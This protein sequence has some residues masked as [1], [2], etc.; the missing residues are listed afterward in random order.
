MLK[1]VWDTTDFISQLPPQTLENT[2]LVS[3]DVVNL[4]FN[5]PYDLRIKAIDYW[6]KKYPQTLETAINLELVIEGLKFILDNNT[7]CFNIKYFKQVK[8]TAMGTKCAPVDATLVL[9][10]L[11]WTLHNKVG[12][13]FNAE[14]QS[15]F[16]DTWKRFLIQIE[17]MQSALSNK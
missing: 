16:E 1:Y 10:Y 7:F 8:G 2:I 4:Y 11:E 14:L 5:I 13:V 3:F 6:L 9:T 15:Y 12:E 17:T